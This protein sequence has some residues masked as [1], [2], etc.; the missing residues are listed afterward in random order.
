MSNDELIEILKSKIKYCE[1]NA[2][3]YAQELDSPE[4][5]DKELAKASAYQEVINIISL[6]QT[7]NV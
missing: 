5:C 7:P 1:S 6:N 3:E 2:E 4:D